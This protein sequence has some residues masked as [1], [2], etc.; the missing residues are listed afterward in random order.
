MRGCTRRT[1]RSISAARG[2]A[3]C[4]RRHS[5]SPPIWPGWQHEVDAVAG[6][7]L[8]AF[9]EALRALPGKTLLPRLRADA[10]DIA[11]V[12]A[13][14]EFLEQA[15]RRPHL[16]APLYVRDQV[17]LDDRAAP[18]RGRVPRECPA[19]PGDRALSADDTTPTSMTSSGSKRR[20]IR[21]RGRCGNFADSL[22]SG[23]SCWVLRDAGGCAAGLCASSCSRSTRRICST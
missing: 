23:Y 15:R 2:S 8:T 20:S 4:C 22:R 3:R 21:F 14:A 16:A 18:R 17:A 12:A 9:P 5:Q 10:A 7:A 13:T 1:A 19:A 6:D 11:R